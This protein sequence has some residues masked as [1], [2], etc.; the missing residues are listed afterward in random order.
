M[1][2]HFRSAVNIINVRSAV[3][4]QAMDG[5]QCAVLGKVQTEPSK[6]QKNLSKQNLSKTPL[7]IRH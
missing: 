1:N 5:Q 7:C 3:T 2:P 4:E 6:P